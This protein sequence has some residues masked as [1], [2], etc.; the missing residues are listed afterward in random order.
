MSAYIGVLLLTAGLV[1]ATIWSSWK[2]YWPQIRT[3]RQQIA[4]GP[5]HQELRFTIV[6]MTVE[7]ASAVIHRPR[8]AQQLIWEQQISQAHSALRAA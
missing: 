2:R 3:L 7:R 8:F 4:A 1:L 6:T 5:G